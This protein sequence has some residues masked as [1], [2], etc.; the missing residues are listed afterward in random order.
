MV[1]TS[2]FGPEVELCPLRR[3]RTEKM[4]KTAPKRLHIAQISPLLYEIVVGE[5]VLTPDFF[6]K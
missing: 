6:R 2:D 3:M 4:L 1:V 5:M